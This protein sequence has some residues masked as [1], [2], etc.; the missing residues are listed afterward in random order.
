MPSTPQTGK[1]RS[2]LKFLNGSA[3]RAGHFWERVSDGLEIQTLWSQFFSEARASYSLY[4]REVDWDALRH[5]TRFRRFLKIGRALFWAMIMKLSPARRVF[6]LIVLLLLAFFVLNVRP[7]GAP[8][9]AEFLMAIGGLIFL[10]ALELADRVTMKRDL[11]IAR[12]IQRWLVPQAPPRVPG[13]D[14]AFSSRP[15]NTVGGDYFDAFLLDG[16]APAPPSQRLL[17]VVADVAGKSVP[18][19]LLMATFQASLRTV[20]NAATPLTEIVSRINDYACAHS[21]GGRRFTTAF[22]AEFNPATRAL[23][24]L[25]AGHNIPILRRASGEFERPEEGDLPLGINP[26]TRFPSG[27]VTL[28]PGDLLVIFTDGVVEGVNERDQEFG[29][30]RLLDVLRAAPAESAAATLQRL[31]SAVDAFAG[32]ARQHDDITWLVFRVE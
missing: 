11:E 20:A 6:L 7:A 4:H 10:L 25:R 1:S 22:F 24:Y 30:A 19:A 2:P 23:T 13:V 9:E 32:S 17:L 28:A 15:A 27:L 26:G 18:A 12:E 5:E 21:L 8:R 3:Q 14:I 16:A 31:T 29:E